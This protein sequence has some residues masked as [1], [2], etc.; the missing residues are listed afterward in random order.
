MHNRSDI[1]C[2]Q[3]IFLFIYLF[4]C[5][6]IKICYFL[7]KIANL[8]KR[9]KILMLYMSDVTHIR[10]HLCHCTYCEIMRR[11]DKFAP[12]VCKELADK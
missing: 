7:Y 12:N 9:D 3:S 4:I 6:L 5:V 1:F 8:L 10:S 2:R 11:V